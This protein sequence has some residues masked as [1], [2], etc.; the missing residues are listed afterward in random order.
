MADTNFP[1]LLTLEKLETQKLGESVIENFALGCIFGELWLF[2]PFSIMAD[3]NFVSIKTR[4]T[5]DTN[6]G[7]LVISPF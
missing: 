4:K 6:L 5:R 2:F 1:F 7:R 3:T